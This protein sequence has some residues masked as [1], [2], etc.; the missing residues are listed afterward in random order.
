MP[1]NSQFL[2][3]TKFIMNKFGEGMRKQNVLIVA[4]D[5]LNPE[6]M[7]TLAIINNEINDIKA[8]DETGEDIDLDKICFK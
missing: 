6:V 4:D 2:V 5:V 3:N 8:T 1:E 7:Q